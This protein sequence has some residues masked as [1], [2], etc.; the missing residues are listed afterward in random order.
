MPVLN[1]VGYGKGTPKKQ[2]DFASLFAM[3]LAV[4]ETVIAKAQSWSWPASEVYWYVDLTAGP[5]E[6]EGLTGSPLLAI[7]ALSSGAAPW[8]AWLCERDKANAAT[9]VQ[10]LRERGE[11][12]TERSRVL[13]GDHRE[14]VTQILFDMASVGKR[15][16]FGL[17]YADP[18]GTKLDAEMDTIRRITADHEKLDV[19]I[20]LSATRLKWFKKVH[21]HLSLIDKLS[22]IGKKHLLIRE[23]WTDQQ[24]T[25]ALLTNWAG[26]PEWRSR[27]F[28]NVQTAK[29]AAV[30]ETLDL[31]Q[32]D[33]GHKG[34]QLELW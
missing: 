28:H 32:Q 34:G 8:R 25:F 22:S 19:L 5:G 21:G 6:Y 7:D 29:G 10:L 3:H 18:N 14:S 20:H 26:Y 11:A 27:G 30:L 1:G 2:E 33:R 24:W 9:L 16:H 31:S 17:I 23:P 13:L 12:V 15:A 4:T